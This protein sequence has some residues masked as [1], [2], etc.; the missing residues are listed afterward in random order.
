MNDRMEMNNMNK[1]IINAK[2]FIFLFLV[3]L[4]FASCGRVKEKV[5]ETINKSGETVGKTTTEF[6]E[7]V[8]EGIDKTLQCELSLS[9]SLM[10]KG[11]KTGKFSIENSEGGRNN[12]LTVYL[13]FDRDFKHFVTAKAF[14]KNGLEVGRAKIEIEGKT[15]EAAYFE[16]TFD[17]RTYIEVKSKIVLE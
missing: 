3:L 16:F 12:L 14:D 11:L 4:L 15:D 8:S 1:I 17:K 6:F 13:I 10:E 9:N 7:G 2:Y 5:R